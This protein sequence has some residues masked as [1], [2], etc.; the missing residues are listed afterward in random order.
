MLASFRSRRGLIYALSLMTIFLCV[1]AV[2]AQSDD[3]TDPVKLFEKGQDAHAK[4][5]YK[6]AIDLYDAALKLKPEFAEA[7]F[8]RA[9]AL[10]STNRKPEAIEGFQRA[11]ALR[12][13]WTLAYET[14]GVALAHSSRS[15]AEPILRKAFALDDKNLE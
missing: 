12:P 15:E 3:D 9:M 7:E 10:L 2:P 8:Q 11:V 14:F 1:Q 13:D 4:S 5:D 6:L